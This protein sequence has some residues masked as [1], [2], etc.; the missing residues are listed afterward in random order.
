MDATPAFSL[1]RRAQGEDDLN[2]SKQK[3]IDEDGSNSYCTDSD[4]EKQKLSEGDEDDY[5]R[6]SEQAGGVV[7]RI[8]TLGSSVQ[9]EVARVMP[10]NIAFQNLSYSVK[11]RTGKN[12]FRPRQQ[13][14]LLKDLHG[15]L[16]PGEVT[17]IMGPSGTALFCLPNAKLAC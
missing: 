6:W 10:V 2:E 3:L 9:A 1:R 5:D 14:L 8:L 15:H 7:K 4:D 13:K 11:V 16:H 17:A 12:P